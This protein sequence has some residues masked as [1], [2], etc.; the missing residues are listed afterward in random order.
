M[1]A[2][3]LTIPEP[4]RPFLRVGTCSW[5]DPTWTGLI[6][7]EG[8]DYGPF[9]YLPDYARLLRTVE[10]DQWFWSLFPPGPKLP[11][12]ETAR[13]Y[14]ESVP[15]DFVFTVKVPNAVTLTHF[16]A[17]QPKSYRAHANRPN[18]H[19]LSVDLL[20]EFLRTLEPMGDKLG[21]LIFQF[22]YLNRQKMASLQAFL[23]QLGGFF[24]Q[25]PAGYLYAVETRNPNYLRQSFFDFLG[26]RDLGFVYLDGYYMPPIIDVFSS[27]DTSPAPFTIIRLHGADRAAIE[28][29]TGKTWNRVVAPQPHGLQSA[30]EIVNHNLARA[31]QTF[32][33]V[34]NHYEGSAPLTIE[35]FVGLLGERG[36]GAGA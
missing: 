3:D 17:R 27:A 1:A 22:E 13:R 24:D 23:D 34:N 12:P 8:V 19:F 15:E 33:N 21:P 2:L 10:V 14:A 28:K 36:N 29:T 20:T 32:V 30:V 5:K 11:D 9:D 18:E 6:Y 16:Y 25:A 4:Y 35:R 26:D 31:H 7:R